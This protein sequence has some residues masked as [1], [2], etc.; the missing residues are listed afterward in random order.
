MR[1]TRPVHRTPV[2]VDIDRLGADLMNPMTYCAGDPHAMWDS[3][4]HEIPVARHQLPDG[5]VYWSVTRHQDCLRVVED[6]E[7]FTSEHG[8]MLSQLGK[9]DSAGGRQM[10]VS[11]PPQHTRL[12]APLQELMSQPALRPFHPRLRSYVR[13][14]LAPMAR[15]QPWDIADAMMAMPMATA[16]LLMGLPRVDWA[17]LQ[18]WTVMAIAA[19]DPEFQIDGDRE[20][21]LRTAHTRL[22]GYFLNLLEDRRHTGTREH[23]DLV[24]RLLS[25]DD[26]ETPLSAGDLVAN[27]YSLLLGANITSAHVPAAVILALLDHQDRYHWWAANP[28]SLRSGVEEALRWASPTIHV[29]RHATA[30]VRLHGQL[31]R[32][33]EAV[34]AWLASANRDESVFARPYE[35]DV[36]RA[37]NRHLAFGAGVHYCIGA[38]TARLGLRIVF[39]ELFR[40]VEAFQLAGPVEHL[41]S[42]FV[43]G[44]KHMPVAV[45]L[46]TGVRIDSG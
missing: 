15:E 44:V 19:D 2:D 30:D 27:C 29:M 14:S 3:L 24:S 18:Q 16:A 7:T 6:H 37:P 34:V 36:K 28:G 17:D 46:R 26:A 11:N 35:F 43:A 42:T 21:T 31:I 25:I 13:E 10:V 4:R 23:H 1:I 20:A 22:F 41:A 45:R 39:E 12:R 38:V 40:C 8:I 33:G 5:R 32:K 9:P